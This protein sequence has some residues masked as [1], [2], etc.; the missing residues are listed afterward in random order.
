[1]IINALNEL[2]SVI[3]LQQIID[4][5][6]KHIFRLRN[7][8]RGIKIISSLPHIQTIADL[9]KIKGIGDGIRRRVHEILTKGTLDEVQCVN[10]EVRE[11]VALG[12]VHGIG[13]KLLASLY[14]R[15]IRSISA[16]SRALEEGLPDDIKIYTP[17]RIALRYHSDLVRK[18]PREFITRI[19]QYLRN[20]IPGQYQI[21]GS[22]RRGA[23]ESSDIDVLI[24]KS[25]DL[26]SLSPLID[27]LREDGFLIAQLS[28]GTEKYNGICYFAGRYCRIDLLLSSESEY[29]PALL[30]F[31]GS[32]L[33]NQIIRWYANKY[34]YKLSNLGLSYRSPTDPRPTIPLF[35][36]EMEIF[37]YLGLKYLEPC[38]REN[39]SQLFYKL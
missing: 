31:T 21:C 19:S 28:G 6:K 20:H 13:P 18:I 37:E 38:D 35:T 1:M 8:N 36:S 10:Q 26:T 12:K 32:G 15:G 14:H 7:I 30:H 25:D 39:G 27:T 29:Y 16:L 9:P 11:V 33:F 5:D 4:G 34:G 23:A 24:M 2:V 17:T 22:Y 3:K